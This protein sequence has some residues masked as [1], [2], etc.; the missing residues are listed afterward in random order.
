MFKVKTRFRRKT[1]SQILKDIGRS[2]DN[3]HATKIQIP[4]KEKQKIGKR[5]KTKRT[6]SLSFLFAVVIFDIHDVLLEKI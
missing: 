2:Y 1:M 6:I 3:N 4:K 5:K